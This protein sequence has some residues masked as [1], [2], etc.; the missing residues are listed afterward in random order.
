[1]SKLNLNPEFTDGGDEN[2]LPTEE[3]KEDTTE[4]TEPD[5]SEGEQS[6]EEQ[7]T[8]EKTEEIANDKKTSE[9][10]KLKALE[11]LRKQEDELGKDISD[12]DD[13]IERRRQS[14]SQKRG[15]RRE[16]RD[17]VTKIGDKLPETEEDK[18]EDIDSTT[19]NILERYTKAKGLVPKSELEQYNYD[20]QH[21]TAEQSFY[22]KHTE[23]LPQNDKDDVL[24]NALKQELSL[25]AR[26]SNP[27]LIAKLFEKAHAE[28]KKQ[29]PRFFKESTITEK[30]N[31]NQR[32]NSAALGGGNTGGSTPK[33]N[34]D[35]KN[36]SAM[37]IQ[38][39]RQGGWSEEEISNLN[40]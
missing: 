15:E 8:E 13:E 11:A 24:Y 9:S 39:L 1:M 21:K 30:V 22:E 20:S 32:I 12:L 19:L 10:E 36:L 28:V 16:K 14:I 34:K 4:T 2:A 23:Y 7:S 25:Y 31:A 38:A 40:S 18:L 37:Q 29:Y 33:P 26:P 6:T 17:L 3:V 27:S 5:A 35:A